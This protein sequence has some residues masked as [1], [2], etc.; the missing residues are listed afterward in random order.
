MRFC[1]SDSKLKKHTLGSRTFVIPC[2]PPPR[3]APSLCHRRSL[4]P[5]SSSHLTTPSPFPPLLLILRNPWLSNLASSHSLSRSSPLDLSHQTRELKKYL[6]DE[7]SLRRSCKNRV[8]EVDLEEIEGRGLVKFVAHLK[9]D[10]FE[11]IDP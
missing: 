7:D 4:P 11:F 2:L 3:V 6:Y 8:P 5:F 9:D 10:E 1:M